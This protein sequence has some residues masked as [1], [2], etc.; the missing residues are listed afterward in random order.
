MLGDIPSGCDYDLYLYSAT[1]SPLKSGKNAGT[2]DELFSYD[3]TAG[4]TY[5]IKVESYNGY[6]SSNA[7]WMRAKNYPT[8]GGGTGDDH[9]NGSGNATPI[10]AN[11]NVPGAINYPG[12]VDCF[13]ITP[14][15]TGTYHIYTTSNGFDTYASLFENPY[16][17]PLASD[18][19]GNGNG[20]F[21]ITYTLV[22]GRT[23][24]IFVRAYSNTST[25]SYTLRAD[26]AGGS[27]GDPDIPVNPGTGPYRVTYHGNGH[28]GGYPPAPVDVPAGYRYSVE[29][30]GNM[31]RNGYT[32]ECWN[33]MPNG[34]GDDYEPYSFYPKIGTISAPVT[35]YAKWRSNISS[36]VSV[37]FNGNGATSGTLPSS[38]SVAI[39]S[40]IITPEAGRLKKAGYT[41]AGWMS[42][43][44]FRVYQE[45]VPVTVTQSITLSAQWTTDLAYWYPY[46]TTAAGEQGPVSQQGS[47]CQEPVVIAIGECQDNRL[48]STIKGYADF[49]RDMWNNADFLPFTIS[50]LS[51]DS[52]ARH[53]VQY[54]YGTQS[55]MGNETGIDLSG[56]YGFT[57][58]TAFDETYYKNYNGQQKAI[59]RFSGSS[60]YGTQATIYLASECAPLLRKNVAG[61]ELGHVLGWDGHVFNSTA[62]LMHVSTN[63]STNN[64]VTRID[65]L[66]IRQFYDLFY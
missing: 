60:T 8:P 57:Y 51:T 23:Y 49:A 58:M 19:D 17:S 26:Y 31:V 41:F 40:T 5:Y 54:R 53:T 9:A 11:T 55:W 47:F 13:R 3:V 37:T 62:P 48:K 22:A 27:G 66:Q 35:L 4:E 52:T 10:S 56:A 50:T 15:N 63:N 24:Y 18:D 38:M 33:T 59:Q 7:Y 61:H 1:V 16:N 65:K 21:R 39:G 34:N 30:P 36:T 44:T 29:G 42:S 25:G 43:D 2:A 12:D 46:Q 32:F 45:G 14:T 20:N 64:T 6:S 28:T